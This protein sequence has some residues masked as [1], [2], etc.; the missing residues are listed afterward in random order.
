M[1]ELIQTD[2]FIKVLYDGKGVFDAVFSYG[3]SE[4]KKAEQIRR[5][6]VMIA[7][8]NTAE[9]VKRDKIS[10]IAGIF[11]PKSWKNK[12]LLIAAFVLIQLNLAQ[13]FAFEWLIERMQHGVIVGLH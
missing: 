1:Y 13:W 6:R 7:T 8:S 12:F 11:R 5:L 4:D 9:R 2:S 10:S 3:I